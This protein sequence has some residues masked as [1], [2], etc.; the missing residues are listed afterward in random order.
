MN[1]RFKTAVLCWALM[2]GKLFLV[3]VVVSAC[4]NSKKAEQG[5]TGKAGQK[6]KATATIGMISDI[7]GA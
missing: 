3:L 2:A 6:I 1:K 4:T 5:A 7:V